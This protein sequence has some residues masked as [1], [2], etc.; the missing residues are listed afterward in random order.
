MIWE[1]N[2]NIVHMNFALEIV[3]EELK[4]WTSKM[5]HDFMFRREMCP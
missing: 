3:C 1:K 5:S 4:G 2:F